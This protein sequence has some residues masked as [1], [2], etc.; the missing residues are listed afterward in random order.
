MPVPLLNLKMCVIIWFKVLSVINEP[1]PRI[2][3]SPCDGVI[4]ILCPTC[5]GLGA[6]LVSGP[7]VVVGD[8]ADVSGRGGLAR[9]EA[10]HTDHPRLQ[11]SH[12]VGQGGD[13]TRN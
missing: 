4:H 1:C 9:Y 3:S 12:I 2:H 7:E 13:L 8:G 11:S 10:P 5:D 6:A